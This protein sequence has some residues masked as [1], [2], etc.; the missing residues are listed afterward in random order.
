MATKI[1]IRTEADLVKFVLG[2]LGDKWDVS[3]H[4]TICTE[5]HYAWQ[6]KI[7]K[8]IYWWLSVSHRGEIRISASIL[9]PTL[10]QLIKS[11]LQNELWE[12]IR[13]EF[14]KQSV[15]W[16]SPGQPD[17][18]ETSQRKLAA[19]RP[20]I[21]Q[22][23]VSLPAPSKQL[24][25]LPSAAVGP[26]CHWPGCGAECDEQ[27]WACRRHWQLMTPQLQDFISQKYRPGL[28]QSS[29]YADVEAYAFRWIKAHYTGESIESI[30]S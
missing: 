25:L 24:L 14:L 5:K 29:E 23:Q 18:I 7:T 9:K 3:L 15:Q 8:R 27:A 26:T 2:I 1:E 17:V 16:P 4:E 30:H 13:E 10:A 22:K 11:V 21:A 28:I 20:R 12:K 6:S 19:K